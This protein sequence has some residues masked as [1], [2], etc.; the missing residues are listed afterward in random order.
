MSP[1]GRCQTFDALGNGYGRGEGIISAVLQHGYSSA[2][3]LAVV[4]VVVGSGIN[5]DGRS[6]GLTVPHGPSQANLIRATLQA[7]AVDPLT[8][9]LVSVHGTGTPLGDPIEVEALRQIS[10]SRASG[11]PEACPLLLLSN[12]ATYGHTEG[13]AG[14][15]SVFT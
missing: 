12:K 3:L 14:V 11:V 6:S 15:K 13:S 10:G 8:V 2:G 5:Q 7:A 4:A 9:A 1:V